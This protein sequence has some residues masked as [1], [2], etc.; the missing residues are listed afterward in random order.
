[1]TATTFPAKMVLV[2]ARVLL[3]V[4]KISSVVGLVLKSKDVC[5]NILLNRIKR[6]HCSLV[7]A[8]F[9]DWL[10]Q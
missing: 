3:S 10:T 9:L 1:M 2:H 7:F 5:S 8:D 6:Y 4:E